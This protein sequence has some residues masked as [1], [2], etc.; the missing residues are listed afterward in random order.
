MLITL[1]IYINDYVRI[2]N[3]DNIERNKK[4][5]VEPKLS[6][7]PDFFFQFVHELIPKDTIFA[8][9]YMVH[10]DPTLFWSNRLFRGP[11]ELASSSPASQHIVV[12][13]SHWIKGM[14]Q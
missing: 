1:Y 6:E 13:D 11:I 4:L 8:F 12:S 2:N 9:T 7:K 3:L 14:E 5:F 10:Q